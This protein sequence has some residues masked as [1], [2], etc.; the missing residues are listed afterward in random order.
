M[1]SVYRTSPICL[2]K[3]HRNLMVSEK[4]A[5]MLDFLKMNPKAYIRMSEK[6]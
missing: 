5:L 2:L 3:K 4:K 6:S 1:S